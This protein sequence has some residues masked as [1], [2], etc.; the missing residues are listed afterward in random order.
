M[1][2]TLE[3]GLSMRARNPTARLRNRSSRVLQDVPSS[4]P[5]RR[6]SVRAGFA[7][8][9]VCPHGRSGKARSGWA[10]GTRRSPP[11]SV[12]AA[13]SRGTG[14]IPADSW[15]S[16]P[17]RGSAWRH[18]SRNP[19]APARMTLLPRANSRRV[20]PPSGAYA[21]LVTRDRRRSAPN[22]ARARRRSAVRW[23]CPGQRPSRRCALPPSAVRSRPRAR[24]GSPRHATTEAIRP[25]VDGT[26]WSRVRASAARSALR[27]VKVWW[28]V[29]VA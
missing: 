9:M 5:Q 13:V 16:R 18:V 11:Q 21:T 8:A 28:C 24:A 6:S 23:L 3:T 1:R 2:V 29:W 19:G 7:R 22:S 20:P 14:P 12:E 27:L 17:D 4:P 25:P 26:R 15:P 10:P